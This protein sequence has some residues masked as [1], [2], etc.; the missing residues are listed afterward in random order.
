[1]EGPAAAVEIPP[2]IAYVEPANPIE[3]RQ[4]E[5][6]ATAEAASRGAGSG[7]RMTRSQSAASS[8]KTA[9]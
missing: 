7:R 9:R 4:V 5:V 2:Q 8:G 6:A 1:V 3:S